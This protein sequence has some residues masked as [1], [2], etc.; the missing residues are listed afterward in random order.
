MKPLRLFPIAAVVLIGTSLAYMAGCA[1]DVAA[2]LW[3]QQIAF[4]GKPSISSVTPASEALP[5]VDVITIYG[6][7]LL[8]HSGT[9]TIPDT[10]V[11]LF[12]ATSAEVIS[13]DSNVITV[14]RPNLVTDSCAIKVVPHNAMAVATYAPYKVD[15]V[16]IAY[17]G[18]ED[19]VPLSTIAIDTS[20]KAYVV[21]TGTRKIHV[22][23]SAAANSALGSTT[24]LAPS[25]ARIGP[26]GNMYVMEA[27]R[28]I[29]KVTL[30]AGTV[31]RWTQLPQGKIVKAG[32]FNTT[33]YF[34]TGGARTG[35]CIVPPNPPNPIPLAQI[36]IAG[37]Y[38]TE[39]ILA[40]RVFDGSVYVA[41]RPAG[42]TN[43]AKIWKHQIVAD[44]VGTQNLV[45]DLS[46][47]K[48]AADLVT[49]LAISSTGIVMIS[50]A[51]ASDPLLKFDPTTSTVV[52][53]YKGIVPPYCV[54]LSWSTSS[55]YLYL[56]SGNTAAG[57]QWRAYRLDIGLTG[58]R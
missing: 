51:S 41:S 21:E 8:V 19:N 32:D 1:Y 30:P 49:D 39:E 46:A 9:T 24:A 35:L 29:D 27:N 5:G 56:I 18:F 23:T 11:V 31:T 20:E 16:M 57:Q 13:L 48:F 53:Y 15:Q 36:R 14:R 2:P 22:T 3:N 26:D 44:S 45:V 33:G 37:A 47:T 43:G 40:V 12:G 25:C 4:P 42:T 28:A 34:Y 54:A 7:N 10:T 52:N 17:G 58:G 55:H 38:L 6:H 50:T